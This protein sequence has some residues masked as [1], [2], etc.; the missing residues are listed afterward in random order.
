MPE[1]IKAAILASANKVACTS[2]KISETALLKLAI[3]KVRNSHKLKR[4]WHKEE[5]TKGATF[6]ANCACSAVVSC[7]I[8]REVLCKVGHS[9]DFLRME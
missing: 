7:K 9:V 4:S 3:Q 1:N 8:D 5:K 6:F 2:V